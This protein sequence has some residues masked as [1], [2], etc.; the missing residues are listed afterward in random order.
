MQSEHTSLSLH[1]VVRQKKAA[2][3]DRSLVCERRYYNPSLI[4]LSV[5]DKKD[6]TMSAI[7]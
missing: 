4:L 1:F 7:S 3:A 6:A 2:K 5:L